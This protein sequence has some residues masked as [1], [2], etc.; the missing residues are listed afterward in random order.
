MQ[1]DLT[2]TGRGRA[3]VYFRKNIW[4]KRNIVSEVRGISC[5]S[6]IYC[7]LL[8][9]MLKSVLVYVGKTAESPTTILIED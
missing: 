1:H 2:L 8:S 9:K 7:L 4:M 5:P 6:C 3:K